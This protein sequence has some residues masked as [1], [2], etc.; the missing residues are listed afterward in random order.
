MYSEPVHVT[1]II[2]SVFIMPSGDQLQHACQLQ[3][4]HTSSGEDSKSEKKWSLDHPSGGEG[5][6]GVEGGRPTSKEGSQEQNLTTW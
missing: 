5:T 2:Y 4:V 1:S 3:A 6:Q